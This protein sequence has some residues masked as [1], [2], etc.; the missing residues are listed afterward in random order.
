MFCY[1]L[2]VQ[3]LE[4]KN[5]INFIVY[6]K[7]IEFN[8]KYEIAILNFLGGRKEKFKI[9]KYSKQKKRRL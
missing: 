1:I 7:Q 5:M 6:E 3:L 9:L 2:I 4:A 8:D